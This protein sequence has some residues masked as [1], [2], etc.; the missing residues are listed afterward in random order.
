[1]K[2]IHYSSVAEEFLRIKS[3][4]SGVNIFQVS[5]RKRTFHRGG[6][7]VKESLFKPS[8][9]FLGGECFGSFPTCRKKQQWL[10]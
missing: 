6:D 9:F 4:E 8:G 2:E 7:T 10:N 3:H 1:M 5:K